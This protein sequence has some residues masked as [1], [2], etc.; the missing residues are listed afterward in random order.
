MSMLDLNAVG[1]ITRDQMSVKVSA[2]YRRELRILL[3]YR[4]PS[5]L[6]DLGDYP[7]KDLL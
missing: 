5:Y 3:T 2:Y 6:K 4:T 7:N 1:Q